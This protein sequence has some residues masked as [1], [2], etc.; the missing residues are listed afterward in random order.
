MASSGEGVG[1][2]EPARTAGGERQSGSA[3]P[4]D[5]FGS[6]LKATQTPYDPE[7]PLRIYQ[8]ELKTYVRMNRVPEGS[9]Q[10][11]PKQPN[12]HQLV[13]WI[14]KFWQGRSRRLLRKSNK[15]KGLLMKETSVARLSIFCSVKEARRKR[16]RVY[17]YI[18][19]H[20]YEK[21]QKRQ[22]LQTQE[23]DQWLAEPGVEVGVVCRRHFGSFLQR[24]APQTGLGMWS[25]SL[26]L[27]FWGFPPSL[28]WDGHTTECL[29]V[30]K[31][32]VEFFLV[33]GR[34]T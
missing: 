3:P 8:R 24:N 30:I 26:S 18:C 12:A 17:I 19:F 33:V 9:Q 4:G 27:L 31:S 1:R 20:F 29:M 15:R 14:N 28:S 23:A 10:L 25:Q 22:N 2:L 13:Q 6:F 16:L 21:F 32:A 7:I 5:Q 11:H 34:Q